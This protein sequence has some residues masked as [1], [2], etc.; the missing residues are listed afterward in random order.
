MMA[1][2]DPL[3]LTDKGARIIA[4]GGDDTMDEEGMILLEI[5]KRAPGI[6]K[7]DLQTCFV[8]LRMEYGEHALEAIQS[9]HVQFE[10]RK[11]Q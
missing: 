7:A 10:S 6:S 2:D 4:R 11:P 1:V 8:T 5:L 9:G 3:G